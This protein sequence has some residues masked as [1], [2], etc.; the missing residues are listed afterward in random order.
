MVLLLENRI[1]RRTYCP[2]LRL[3][4][5]RHPGQAQAFVKALAAGDMDGMVAGARSA[6]PPDGEA[7]IEIESG[8]RGFETPEM[9]KRCGKKEVAQRLVRVQLDRPIEPCDCLLVAAG[10]Q[11][12]NCRNHQPN[13]RQTVARTDPQRLQDMG[14]GFLIAPN[15]ILRIAD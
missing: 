5:L 12:G 7:R 15:K 3:S 11:L 1:I 8:A 9:R 2:N 4:S 14:L 13:S 10:V 6:S